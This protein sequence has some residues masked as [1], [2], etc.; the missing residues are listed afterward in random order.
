MSC[1]T[2]STEYSYEVTSVIGLGERNN[3]M[4]Y[5]QNDNN[6]DNIDATQYI[7]CHGNGLLTDSNI[8]PSQCD[9]SRTPVYIWTSI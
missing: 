1:K 7:Y 8:G 5:G 4:R 9:G 2:N 3:C 6:G